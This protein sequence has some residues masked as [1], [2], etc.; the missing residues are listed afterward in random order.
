MSQLKVSLP[1]FGLGENM[2]KNPLKA[3]PIQGLLNSFTNKFV[4][5][6]LLFFLPYYIYIYIYIAD[7]VKFG[8]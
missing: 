2:A 7:S 1:T 5:I 6:L 3:P 8:N 4:F